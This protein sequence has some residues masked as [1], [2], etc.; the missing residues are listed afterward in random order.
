[1][2]SAVHYGHTFHELKQLKSTNEAGCRQIVGAALDHYGID[3]EEPD[4]F[5]RRERAANR[6]PDQESVSQALKLFVRD[7]AA[8]GHNERDDTFP[9]IKRHLDLHFPTKAGLQQGHSTF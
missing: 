9:C 8:E 6:K 3:R 5:A 7:W 4:A 2:D 1:M